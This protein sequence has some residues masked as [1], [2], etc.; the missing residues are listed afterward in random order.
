MKYLKWIF[1]ILVTITVLVLKIIGL[2]KQEEK[3]EKIIRASVNTAIDRDDDEL[4][5]RL[6]NPL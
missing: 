4:H 3:V 1:G 2:K 6:K 5:H